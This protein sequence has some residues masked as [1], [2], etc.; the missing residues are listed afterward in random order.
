MR[1]DALSA[2]PPLKNQK[3][4]PTINRDRW[5]PPIGSAERT[6]KPPASAATGT[7]HTPR[8][9]GKGGAGKP[10][11]P[12]ELKA[13]KKARVLEGG[14][15][16]FRPLWAP[17]LTSPQDTCSRTSNAVLGAPRIQHASAPGGRSAGALADAP[18]LA[19]CK[20]GRDLPRAG[21][22][23]PVGSGN[24]VIFE[25]HGS[26]LLT[27]RPEIGSCCWFVHIIST[28]LGQD[29]DGCELSSKYKK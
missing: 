22:I 23:P 24:Q 7:H 26:V 14:L 12:A 16:L 17:A 20:H 19:F 2:T 25:I 10:R 9:V 27:E 8:G 1:C 18:R 5:H 11:M 3:K 29:G 21:A 15:R 13:C 4:K 6:R 28:Q